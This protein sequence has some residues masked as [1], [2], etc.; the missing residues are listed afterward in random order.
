MLFRCFLQACLYI[1]FNYASYSNFNQ[2]YNYS[3]LDSLIQGYE[4]KGNLK[5]CLALAKV[6]YQKSNNEFEI[7]DSTF[8]YYTDLLGVYYCLNGHFDSAQSYFLKAIEI[9]KKTVGKNHSNYFSAVNNLAFAYEKMGK[10]YEAEPLLLEVLNLEANKLGKNHPDYA[11]TLNN[12]AILYIHIGRNQDAESLVLEALAIEKNYYGDSSYEYAIS[13]NN[14]CTIYFKSKKFEKAA[15][16]YQKVIEIQRKNF[17]ENHFY[18]ANPLNNLAKVYFG[19]EKYEQTIGL[20]K[21]SLDL[22]R[23]IYGANNPIYCNVVNN[24]ALSHEKLG[25]LNQAK[26]L[27]LEAVEIIANSELKNHPRHAIYLNN[28]ARINTKLGKS[29]IARQQISKALSITSGVTLNFNLNEHN[30]DYYTAIAFPSNQ[31]IL[32]FLKT[33]ETMFDF[34][35][36]NKDTNSK[37]LQSYI[38]ELSIHLLIRTKN[39]YRTEKDKLIVL[40]ETHKW[41]LK[42]FAM[43]NITNEKGLA[44]ELAELNKSVLLLEA[45]KSTKAYQISD[46]PEQLIR[47]EFKLHSMYD[48]LENK[49][50]QYKSQ[51]KKDSIRKIINEVNIQLNEFKNLLEEKYPKYVAL[52]FQSNK[53]SIPLIQNKLKKNEALL[54]YMVGDTLIYAFYIDKHRASITPLKVQQQQ[55]KI[56]LDKL[57][58]SISNTNLIKEYLDSTYYNF[59]ESAYWCYQ[60]LVAPIIRGTQDKTTLI[61][62]ADQELSQI[63]FEVFLAKKPSENTPVKNLNYLIKDYAISYHYSASLWLENQFNIDQLNKNSKMLAIAAQYNTNLQTNRKNTSLRI[64]QQYTALPE[65]QNEVKELAKSFEGYFC[66]DSVTTTKQEFIKMASNYNII[67]LAMHGVLDQDEPIFS[68]LAFSN[69]R[70]VIDPNLLHAYEISKLK[71]SAKLA[72]LS[73]CDTGYGQFEQGNGMASLARA[74]MYAGVPA[75]VVSMWQV[76]DLA[77]SKIIQQFYEN[78]SEGMNKAEALRHAKLTYI[79]N[80]HG[81]QAHPLYWAPFVQIGQHNPIQV[82][83]KTNWIFWF[84]GGL[85]LI[86]IGIISYFLIINKF[87]KIK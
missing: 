62:V 31:H 11:I 41:I 2:S 30:I 40:T 13:L 48:S 87:S 28:L 29:N 16:L 81:L 39:S 9:N 75:L 32:V 27:L 24:L 19:M 74:F 38:A 68:G 25:N 78:L 66:F 18:Y 1:F 72:V 26:D 17:G 10:Y 85:I 36:Y 50:Y 44:F 34:L 82:T 83:K 69:T 8:A 65:A 63:P 47:K 35:L 3:E 59:Q 56:Q 77:T 6:A 22:Y 64:N 5:K 49:L 76:D 45:T 14:L 54:E 20:Y 42:R 67:H 71:L 61:I 37:K 60:N 57:R 80:A 12:L 15:Q 53:I 43:L 84:G 46:L 79:N 23:R 7:L 33:L 58:T 4:V 51:Y 86:M 55:L 73:A 52:K 70:N 21:E